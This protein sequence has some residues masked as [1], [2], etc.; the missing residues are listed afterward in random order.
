MGAAARA[1]KSGYHMGG[2]MRRARGSSINKSVNVL[3]MSE[4]ANL[5]LYGDA[6]LLGNSPA[7][8]AMRFSNNAIARPSSAVLNRP[9]RPSRPSKNALLASINEEGAA[10]LRASDAAAGMYM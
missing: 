4:S 6:D 1:H 10:G 9:S 8:G 2:D 3:P 7:T 5:L